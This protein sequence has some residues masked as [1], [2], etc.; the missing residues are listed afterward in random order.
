MSCRTT[1][2]GGRYTHGIRHDDHRTH[3]RH[4]GQLNLG[5]DTHGIRHDDH[6]THVC[7][8]GQ[9]DLGTGTHMELDMMT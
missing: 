8:V 1:E 4:V 7:H 3:V 5:T 6:S 9:L 2:P